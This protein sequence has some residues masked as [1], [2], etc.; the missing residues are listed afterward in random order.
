MFQDEEEPS[1]DSERGCGQ[2]GH[3]RMVQFL[4]QNCNNHSAITR[5]ESKNHHVG[6]KLDTEKQKPKAST[7]EKKN[8]QIA[9]M[10]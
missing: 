9:A 5:L 7:V 2:A 8:V 3:G 6:Y 10:C 1:E 4:L